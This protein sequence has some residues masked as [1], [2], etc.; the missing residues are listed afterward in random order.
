MSHLATRDLLAEICTIA[1]F[2][3]FISALC[4]IYLCL[5][6]TAP[7][8]ELIRFTLAQLQVCQ[9]R[10]IY[11]RPIEYSAYLSEKRILGAL[12]EGLLTLA[13]E[14]DGAVPREE[15]G[16]WGQI[17]GREVV[18]RE[19]FGEWGGLRRGFGGGDM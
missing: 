8:V 19:R 3:H 1:A 13:R 6:A 18:G 2:A 7:E 4:D 14:V 12:H 9:S 15:E 10:I 17:V 11:S 16:L 5:P